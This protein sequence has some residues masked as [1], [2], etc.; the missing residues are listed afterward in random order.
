MARIKTVNTASVVEDTALYALV[1]EMTS[2]EYAS[3][4]ESIKQFGIKVPIHVRS[5]MVLLDGRHRLRAAR[6]LGIERID[7]IIHSFDKEAS[8]AFVRDTAVE[9]RSLTAAQR[10]DVVLKSEELLGTLQETARA[11]SLRNLK[12]NNSPTVPME[13]LG[14]KG[15][16]SEKIAEIARTSR[17][18]V[19]RLRRVKREAPEKYVEVIDGKKSIRKAYDE[20]PPIRKRKSKRSAVQEEQRTTVEQPPTS[21]VT[22]LRKL[23]SNMHGYSAKQKLA[24]ATGGE[25]LNIPDLQELSAEETAEVF[26]T[27]NLGPCLQRV[28]SYM[29]GSGNFVSKAVEEMLA[30]DKDFLKKSCT[31]LEHLLHIIKTILEEN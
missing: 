6:E 3:F 17:V 8:V 29:S 26:A 20:L 19:D 23:P 11:N 27:D 30:E 9:R 31:D 22:G 15:K 1:P 7:V 4:T 5:D 16:T 10:I 18:Q 25:S 12:Q 21:A 24:H 2:S 13:S 14:K 28:S